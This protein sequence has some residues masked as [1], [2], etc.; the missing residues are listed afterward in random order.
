MYIQFDEQI[1]VPYRQEQLVT[2]PLIQIE[3]LVVRIL[4]AYT[5]GKID[6]T[7]LETGKRLLIRNHIKLY[8]SSN[9]TLWRIAQLDVDCAYAV[10][11][12]RKFTTH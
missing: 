1:E 8:G 7:K 3:E 2:I 12:N 11:I 5:K 9:I 10:M 6:P 4:S